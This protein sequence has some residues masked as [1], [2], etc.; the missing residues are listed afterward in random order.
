MNENMFSTPL[1]LTQT[2]V[3]DEF[4]RRTMEL[5][6]R[7]VIPYQWEAINDRVPGAAPSW[8]MHNFRAAARLM[9]DKRQKGAAYIP[10]TYTYRGFEA[11]PED[12]SSPEEDRFYG[13]VFQDTDFSKWIEAV[14]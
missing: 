9:R 3:T 14:G 6:R 7:E 11:L 10:P 13:F 12:P 5:V 4:W 8:C 2:A 1:S